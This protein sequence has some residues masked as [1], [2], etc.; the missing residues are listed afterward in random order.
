MATQCP[1][2]HLTQQKACHIRPD[3]NRAFHVVAGS[4]YTSYYCP[5]LKQCFPPRVLYPGRFREAP[6]QF[7]QNVILP[8]SPSTKPP[9][10]S[11]MDILPP[12]PFGFQYPPRPP[13][14]GIIN[15]ELRQETKGDP[16]GIGASSVTRITRLSPELDFGTSVR[17]APET[18]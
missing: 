8:R 3:L 16:M 7:R 6:P 5:Y 10:L 15:R 12:W 13:P 1:L 9:L 11:P 18:N 4:S 2:L 14:V 17:I